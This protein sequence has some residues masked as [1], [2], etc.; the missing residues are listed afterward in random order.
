MIP[1]SAAR[2][3]PSNVFLIIKVAIITL[4]ATGLFFAGFYFGKPKS[5]QTPPAATITG[6]PTVMRTK[7]G[8]LEVSKI[9]SV[10]QITQIFPG[11]FL[12]TS[13]T[14]TV[15]ATYRY[16]IELAPEW[17]LMRHENMFVAIAPKIKP[18]LPPAFNTEGMTVNSSLPFAGNAKLAVIQQITPLLAQK[19]RAYLSLQREPARR[20]VTEFVTKWVLDQDKYKDVKGLK[21]LVLFADEP[22][23]DILKNGL[24]PIPNPAD[25][26]SIEE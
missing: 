3:G 12:D 8:L 2:L 21:V 4:I 20:T 1:I 9:T 16:H 23:D 24:Y 7:G 19:A 25:L 18:T 26:T 14:V 11:L 13:V 22:I 5:D 17:K 6:H 10:E 15:P